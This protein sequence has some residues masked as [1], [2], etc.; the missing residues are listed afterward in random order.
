MII[1]IFLFTVGFCFTFS[2]K[3]IKLKY[4]F[5]TL[6]NSW[7]KKT[8]V[9]I[10]KI[11]TQNLANLIFLDYLTVNN[12]AKEHLWEIFSLFYPFLWH[13]SFIDTSSISIDRYILQTLNLSKSLH[14][15]GF[16]RPNFTQKWV[17]LNESKIATKQR[18]WW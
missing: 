1:V 16:W 6:L 8:S 17:N 18:K 14:S 5:K 11:I 4:F 13:F 7:R 12:L 10:K 2:G 3:E 9:A 15:R